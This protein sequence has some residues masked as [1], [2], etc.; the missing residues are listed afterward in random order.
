MNKNLILAS[1]S[2]IALGVALSA[3]AQTKPHYVQA[4]TSSAK[5]SVPKLNA[6]VA[7]EG[8]AGPYRLSNSLG[9][10]QN[11]RIKINGFMSAG[12]GR[13]SSKANYQIPGHGSIGDNWN[14]AADSLLGLQVTADI[15]KQLSVVA[16]IVANG[17]NTNGNKGYGL[18][19]DYG[20]I[21]YA[22]NNNIMFRAGRFR[23]PAFM[24]SATQEIGYSYPWVTLPNEVYRIVPFD[25][26]NG[27]QTV[28]RHSLGNTGWTASVEPYIGANSSQF[29]MYTSANSDLSTVGTAKFNENSVIGSVVKIS[30]KYVTLRG[31]Y[32][33]LKLSGKEN[34]LP[35]VT[36]QSDSFYSFG[37]KANFDNIIASSEYAHRDTPKPLASLSGYYAM[38]GYKIDKFLPNIT[39]GRLWT[40]NSGSLHLPQAD[41]ANP[42][43]ATELAQDQESITGGL[44]YYLNSNL[45]LKGSLSDIRPKNGSRGLFD[46]VT[47]N[48][49]K[50]NNLLYMVGV[51][52]VF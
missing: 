39:Y 11:S 26:I 9:L 34:N 6:D 17:D 21:R 49:L 27:F 38:L 2:V 1:C 3:T 36:N 48:K 25:N 32:V 8:K 31:T 15:T 35:V 22:L 45:A 23:L 14:F 16:Q 30:N 24:Y 29:D 28:V 51:D 10:K 52:A 42:L 50:S 19:L 44:D 18:N 13:M 4:K 40:T 43:N 12:V 46:S 41:T 37:A 5:K 33:H 20:F 47:P 7:T